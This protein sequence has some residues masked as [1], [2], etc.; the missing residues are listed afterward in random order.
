M[1]QSKSGAYSRQR[2]SLHGR[3][4]RQGVARVRNMED[5]QPIPLIRYAVMFA[6]DAPFSRSIIAPI[7][8]NCRVHRLP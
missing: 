1:M 6:A 5:Y 3:G 2:C 4:G 7:A 8:E